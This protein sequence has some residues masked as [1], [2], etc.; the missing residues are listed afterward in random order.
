MRRCRT[1]GGNLGSYSRVEGFRVSESARLKP[2]AHA[3]GVRHEAPAVR[4]ARHPL[5]P[6]RLVHARLVPRESEAALPPPLL[7]RL[8]DGE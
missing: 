5:K 8:R 6:V 2:V 4:V 1:I 7:V 3:G